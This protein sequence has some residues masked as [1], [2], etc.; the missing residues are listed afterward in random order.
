MVITIT[1]GKGNKVASGKRPSELMLEIPAGS[2]A[3]NLRYLKKACRSSFGPY[4]SHKQGA[5]T[6]ER[7]G[8]PAKKGD[9][10]HGARLVCTYT[11]APGNLGA[12]L[13][14]GGARRN[15]GFGGFG[16]GN[17]RHIIAAMMRQGYFF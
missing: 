3:L 11:Y 6:L 2:G 10:K 12:L 16:F 15:R 7:N 9:L 13:G 5:F 1:G 14:G 17:R 4:P 8:K